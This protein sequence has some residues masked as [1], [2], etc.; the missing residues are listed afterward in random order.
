MNRNQIFTTVEFI[1]NIIRM[2]IGEYYNEKFYIFD[3]FKCK[4]SGLEDSSIINED[5]VRTVINELISLIKDKTDIIVEEV[6]LCLPSNKLIINEFS[7]TSPVTGKNSLISSYDITE[8]YKT[9][10][11]IRHQEDEMVINIAPIEFVLDDGQKMDFAPVRYKSA[12]FKTSYNVYLLPKEVYNS[13]VNVINDCNLKVSKYYLDIDCMYSGIFEED[14]ISTSI[15]NISDNSTDLLI[16]KKGKL[17]NKVSVGFGTSLLEQELK[18][19]L[20]IADERTLKNVLYNIG[21]CVISNNNYL[22]VCQN[23]SNRYISEHKVNEIIDLNMRVILNQL[24]NKAKNVVELN[25]L[26]VT[27]VGKGSKIKGI[28]VLFKSLCEC[29]ASNYVSSI[30]GLNDPSYCET[31]GLIKLNYKKLSQNKY[32]NLQNNNYNDIMVTREQN[33]KFDRFILDE[34]DLD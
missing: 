18:E 9:A 34:D 24:I 23:S 28:D 12:T 15:L 20:N 1:N 6:L 33:S 26:Y 14:D 7:T 29:N 31:I 16:Y 17:L 27:V 30:L 25:D 10:C 8:A 19:Q 4:C 21:S 13:Y 32:I 5:E 22:S 2:T 3:T 11:K